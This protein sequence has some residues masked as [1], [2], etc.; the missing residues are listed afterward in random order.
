MRGAQIPVFIIAMILPL[1]PSVNRLL[2]IRAAHV[3]VGDW[4]KFVLVTP[5]QFVIGRKFYVA[6]YHALKRGSANMDVLVA[7]G[8]TAAYLYSLFVLL[9]GAVR[10]EY[11][12]DDFFETSAMLIMFV[13]LGKYLEV[14]PRPHFPAT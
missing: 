12:G 6:S 5:V 2:E 10:E 13:L 4:I 8:T 14:P 9:L 3:A 11:E 1:I 7:L